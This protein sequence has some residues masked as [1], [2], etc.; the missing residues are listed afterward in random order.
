VQVILD[1]LRA[2]EQGSGGFPGRAPLGQAQRDLDLLRGQVV[3]RGLVSP[4]GGLAGRGELGPCHLRPR[5]GA[6]AVEHVDR[7][8]K[9]LAGP[10]PLPLPPQ[11]GAVGQVRAGGLEGVRRLGVQGQRGFEVR[12]G[13]ALG[14]DQRAAS[15]GPGQRP[16]LGL[17]ARVAGEFF[18]QLGGLRSAA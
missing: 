6:E 18:G 14:R 4:P 15:R 5:V 11:P 9:L 3:E 2:Q 17:G 13:L 1:G 10:D 7:G 16:G 8:A 12:I